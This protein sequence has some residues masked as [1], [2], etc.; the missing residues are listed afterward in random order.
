MKL[1]EMFAFMRGNVL[2]LSISGALGMFARSMVFPYTPLYIM[3]L[4]GQPA[5]IGIVYALGPLGGLLVFPVAGYLADHVSRV[6]L[7]AYSGFMTGGIIL[8]NVFA[9]SWEWIALARLLQ[10]F[11]VFHFPATSAIVADSLS[12]ENRGRGIAT[13]STVSGAAAIFA[14]FV[15][16][17]LLD[18]YGVDTG[19]RVLYGAMSVSYL[20]SAVINLAFIKEPP[21][22]PEDQ[23]DLFSATDTFKNAYRGIPAMLTQFS[24]PMK[25]L[26]VIII[27]CFVANGL[28][29]PFWVVYAKQNLSLSAS[30]WG[31]VL[32]IESVGRSLS[33]IPA[34]FV[35]DRLGRARFIIGALVVTGILVS[36]FGYGEGFLFVVFIRCAISISGSF[37]GPAC[38]ALLADLI[39][40][41]IRG[42]AMAAIGRGDVRL[43]PASG[44]TGGPGVGFLITIPL[45]IASYCGGVLFQWD[46]MS[47][48]VLVPAIMT[49][50]LFIALLYL[51]DPQKA[52]V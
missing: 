27:L 52:E 19:M 24:K 29:S 4:G 48:W 37:F 35:V 16:G 8:I 3:S 33:G 30:E 7:I 45:V 15:A 50:S 18:I 49:I 11:I 36:L 17:V 51:R 25:A 34:G 38:G 13:M 6:R 12:P 2:V 22:E 47:I 42:R 10:G 40:R 9:A 5:E 31:L 44:G 20:A 21:R 43:A 1:T 46:P 41:S 23:V 39:P 26:S 14:P 32:L 28:A